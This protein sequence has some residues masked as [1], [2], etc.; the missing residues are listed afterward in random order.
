MATIVGSVG[1][2]LATKI[3][4][5]RRVWALAELA[6]SVAN[7][8]V[9]Y[10]DVDPKFKQSVDIYN[11]VMG[12]IGL[13]HVGKGIYTF[14]KNIPAIT[15]DLL[16][17]NKAI[18]T[19]IIAKYLDWKIAVSNLQELT[20]AE[21]QL[22]T[23]QEQV[24]K[25]L[26]CADDALVKGAGKWIDEITEG[27]KAHVLKGEINESGSAVGCHFKGAIDNGTARIRLGA[28]IT[29]GPNDMFKVNID[30][31][32]VNGNW[33]PKTAQSSFFPRTWDEQKILNEIQNAFINKTF[34]SGNTWKGLSS[35]GIEIRMFLKTDGTNQIITAFPIF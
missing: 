8:G 26:G 20:D 21:K 29:E 13:T 1:V 18:K 6:G 34:V 23:K 15:R 35:E 25:M 24:W 30:V 17:N 12:I 7:I 9:N 33:I 32:D 22:V 27:T 28:T 31:K 4:W 5:V 3:H 19:L 14:T 11:G 16:I 10:T 2:L